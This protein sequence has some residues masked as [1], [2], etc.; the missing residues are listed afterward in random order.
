MRRAIRILDL[1]NVQV[2]QGEIERHQEKEPAVVSRATLPPE[3]AAAP[4]QGVLAPGGTAV[5]GGSWSARPE[6]PGFETMEFGSKILDRT[7]WL[8]IMR[9]T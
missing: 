9:R 4:L 2:A 3:R 7:I 5:L 1:E 8:L 6:V